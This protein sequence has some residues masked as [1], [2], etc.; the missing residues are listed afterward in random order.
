MAHPSANGFYQSAGF[1]QHIPAMY[2]AI[3]REFFDKVEAAKQSD[4]VKLKS[5]INMTSFT[6]KLYMELK[7]Y[8][9]IRSRHRDLESQIIIVTNNAKLRK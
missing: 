1:S 6:L 5:T 2:T 8:S 3:S 9:S 4:R 7:S